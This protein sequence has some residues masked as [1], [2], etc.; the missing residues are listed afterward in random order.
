MNR[1]LNL[2]W[3]YAKKADEEKFAIQKRVQG[4]TTTS[5]I[6][7]CGDGNKLYLLNIVY[8]DSHQKGEMLPVIIDVHGGGHMYG[9]VKL[10]QNYC[11]Y[12]A[13]KGFAVVNI[14]YRLLPE[15]DLAGM[16]QDIF[17]AFSWAAQ[18]AASYDLDTGK[19]FITGDSAGG[20]LVMLAL[21]IVSNKNLQKIYSVSKCPLSFR[22]VA[23]SNC[24]T[25]ISPYYPYGFLK[26]GI[27]RDMRKMML[28]E[29]GESAPWVHYM[30]V[31]D[32]LPGSNLPAMLVI[33]SENDFLY[34]HTEKLMELL[35]RHGKHFEKVIW[36]KEDGKE[37]GHV[38]HIGNWDWDKSKITNDKMIDFFKEGM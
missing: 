25:S 13:S 6:D 19:C 38:F 26:K 34:Y 5:D 21:C 18:N 2:M 29:Q 24:V 35:K 15:T 36:K 7:Y 37:L 32:I 1:F 31:E 22:A 20:H 14:S 33:G 10:N 28:G 3:K 11:E 4:V 8:P 27:D 16:V 23:I 30:N 17:R 9:D 12:F